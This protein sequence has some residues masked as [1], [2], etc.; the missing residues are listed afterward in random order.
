M[1]QDQTVLITGVGGYWGAH[2]AARLLT[3][4]AVHVIGIDTAPPKEPIKGL[5]FIQADVRNPLV[6]RPSSGRRRGDARPP[7]LSGERAP[8]RNRVRSERHGHDEG[9][10]RGRDRG[11]QEDRL[12]KQH[13]GL[14]GQAGQLG[15][16]ARGTRADGECD[17]RQRARPGR[18]G[19]LLQRLPRPEPRHHADS[20]AFPQHRGS[21]GRHAAHPFP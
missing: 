12:Q 1:A 17:D 21:P 4:P 7:G 11:R 2:V 16:P 3:L 20:A 15:I 6:D 14:R 5:D 18:G 13:D 10:R 19:G 9:V 8:E